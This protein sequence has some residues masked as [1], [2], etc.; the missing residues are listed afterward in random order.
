MGLTMT[1]S[2]AA[3]SARV[4]VRVDRDRCTGHGLCVLHAPEIFDHD[5]DGLAVVLAQPAGDLADV[6][7]A[8]RN[9][10]ERAI[11]LEELT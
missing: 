6:V 10:P 9:C 8:E 7:E 1:E 3:G 2:A 11:R 5:D 4:R